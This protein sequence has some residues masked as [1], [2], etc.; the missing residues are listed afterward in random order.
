MTQTNDIKQ[1]SLGLALSGGGVKGVAHLGVIKALE[2]IGIKPDIISGV[3]AGAIV[4][5]LYADGHTPE[6]CRDFLYD[7]S[8]FQYVSL[9]LRGKKLG[10]ASNNNLHTLLSNFLKAT[11]FEELQIPLVVNATELYE[12]KNTY[13]HHGPL[14]DKVVASSS[15]PIALTPTVIGEKMYVDGGIF[16]NLPASIIRERC[17]TLIGI[18]VNPIMTQRTIDNIKDVAER[19]YTLMIQSN[20]VIEKHIC[21][22]MIEPIK[23]RNYTTFDKSKIKIIYKIG[24]EAACK[25]I[26]SNKTFYDALTST[27]NTL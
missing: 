24:Y 21:D 20:T 1:H 18:H 5:A 8:Y 6:E 16:C 10:I 13:F 2:E 27:P 3:S 12:G 19:I 11:T 9:G 17:N 23:A 4:G 14:V 15:F 26:E 22:L 25:S 7:S